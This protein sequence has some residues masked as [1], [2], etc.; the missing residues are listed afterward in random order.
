MGE[1]FSDLRLH[2]Q[3]RLDNPLVG[4][5]SLSWIVINY[6]FLMVLFSDSKPELKMALIEASVYPDW[7]SLLYCFVGPLVAAIVYIFILPYP[8]QFVMGFSLKRKRDAKLLR[9]K[10]NDETPLTIEEAASLRKKFNDETR[11]YEKDIAE[12]ESRIASLR[13]QV[14]GM[15]SQLK[16]GER[17]R[18]ELRDKF[19]K[20]LE[21]IDGQ[22]AVR[23]DILRER[24][25]ARDNLYAA[26]SQL[27]VLCRILEETGDFKRIISMDNRPEELDAV[28]TKYAAHKFNLT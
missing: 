1:W 22:E 7:I 18:G 20:S 12:K 10:I 2:V 5:Y 16:E 25:E 28:V 23:E 24:D 11:Q 27:F 6:K 14:E 17:E 9:Q 13:G 3:E 4:A 8:A 19:N 26:N 21:R 15:E